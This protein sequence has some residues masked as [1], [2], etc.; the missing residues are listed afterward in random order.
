M[1]AQAAPYIAHA[2]LVLCYALT[3]CYRRDAE[4]NFLYPTALSASLPHTWLAIHVNVMYE[5]VNYKEPTPLIIVKT[6][7][8][9]ANNVHF[10][11]EYGDVGIIYVV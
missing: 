3:F 5:E 9:T 1:L 2:G 11:T 6:S 4:C 8:L 7:I 10:T